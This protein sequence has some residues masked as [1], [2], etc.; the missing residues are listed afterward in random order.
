MSTVINIRPAS[1]Y[2]RAVSY[3][4]ADTIEGLCF[5]SIARA[6]VTENGNRNKIQQL[7]AV[8]KDIHHK[9]EKQ[10]ID[11]LNNNTCT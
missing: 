4:K 8:F 2:I 3:A 5:N 9:G 1:W 11:T 6:M 10:R 7:K